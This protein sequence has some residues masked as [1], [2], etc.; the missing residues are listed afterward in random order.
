RHVF[1]PPR[2]APLVCLFPDVESSLHS[3]IS[4]RTIRK[5]TAGLDR[6]VNPHLPAGTRSRNRP[7]R[8]RAI[9]RRR[10]HAAGSLNAM[11]P[12]TAIIPAPPAK[13]IGT[14]DNGPPF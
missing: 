11:I 8:A 5:K 1:P 9:P 13:I 2:V 7:A 12:T 3:A 4:T 14:D 6:S 10:G